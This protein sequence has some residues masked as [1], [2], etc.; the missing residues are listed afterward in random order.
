MRPEQ[1][2]RRCSSLQG[3]TL[4]SLGMGVFKHPFESGSQH[5][6]WLTAS[7]ALAQARNGRRILRIHQQVKSGT[8]LD[9]NHAAAVQNRT[10]LL[11]CHLAPQ[12]VSSEQNRSTVRTGNTHGVKASIQRRLVLL[13]TRCAEGKPAPAGIDTI[14]GQLLTNGKARTTGRAADKRIAITPIMLVMK[15]TTTVI[16]DGLI[17]E[18][19]TG[20]TSV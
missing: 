20:D 16:A 8:T 19:R 10:G 6:E 1:H 7:L 15:L 11:Q 4:C 17:R 18:Q 3:S 5:R 14:P 9:G 13:S 12:T 2:N